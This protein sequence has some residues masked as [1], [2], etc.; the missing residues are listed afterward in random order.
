MMTDCELVTV[1]PTDADRPDSQSVARFTESPE[2]FPVPTP[3]ES[4]TSGCGISCLATTCGPR[5]NTIVI[6]FDATGIR[7]DRDGQVIRTIARPVLP[8]DDVPPPQ[9]ACMTRI[10]TRTRIGSVRMAGLT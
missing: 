8:A 2:F 1:T 9:P 5:V 6:L 10:A 4:T 7:R 3:L